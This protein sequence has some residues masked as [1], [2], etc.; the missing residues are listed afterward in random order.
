MIA[1]GLLEDISLYTL[2]SGP[3]SEHFPMCPWTMQ[4][5]H[6]KKINMHQKEGKFASKK[7]ASK[8]QCRKEGRK[9]AGNDGGRKE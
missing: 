1:L 3:T 7:N 6:Q 2:V 4:E 9:E 8:K 5:R